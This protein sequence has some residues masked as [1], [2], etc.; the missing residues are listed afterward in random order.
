LR[1][2]FPK[3]TRNSLKA[4]SLGLLDPITPKHIFAIVESIGKF[5]NFVSVSMVDMKFA[6]RLVAFPKFQ[7][8]L[9][10]SWEG[11]I[12]IHLTLQ[13]G[14]HCS[15]KSNTP[16]GCSGGLGR[17]NSWWLVGVWAMQLGHQPDRILYLPA[18]QAGEDEAD[19]RRGRRRGA[20]QGRSVGS[21]CV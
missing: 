15:Q 16:L 1:A 18:P 3:T 2:K 4:L 5:Y 17:S 13:T 6:N 9:L 21:D 7:R 11:L 19:R 14:G 20:M 8:I 10:F 12:G